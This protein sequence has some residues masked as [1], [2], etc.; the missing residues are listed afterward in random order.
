M[1]PIFL[2]VFFFLFPSSLPLSPTCPRAE[3]LKLEVTSE[4]PGA[5]SVRM[6]PSLTR[7]DAQCSGVKFDH[8]CLFVS[9]TQVIVLRTERSSK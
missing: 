5:P 8:M 2:C 7:G 9:S 1:I 6:V 4:S 3:V